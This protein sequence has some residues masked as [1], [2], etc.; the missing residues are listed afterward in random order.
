MLE[1]STA[2]TARDYVLNNVLFRFGKKSVM[3]IPT[4][5]GEDYAA[6]RWPM[7]HLI[8]HHMFK[9]ILWHNPHHVLVGMVPTDFFWFRWVVLAVNSLWWK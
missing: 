5:R 3:T 8:Y 9:M 6:D 4:R 7:G 2:A 1:D